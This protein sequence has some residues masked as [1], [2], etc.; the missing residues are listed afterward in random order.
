MK[1]LPGHYLSI[2]RNRGRETRYW[3]LRPTPT[4]LEITATDVARVLRKATERHMISDVPVGIYLSGGLDSTSLV[5]FASEFS[6]Q[7]I[8]TFS[9]GFGE[10]NDELTEARAV[11][12]HFRTVHHETVVDRG[13][14]AE[15][16]RLIWHMDSPKRNLYPYYLAQLAGKHVKV[17]LSGLGGD[18]LFAGYDFRYN[19]LEAAKPRTVGQK[20][21]AYLG[22]QARDLPPDQGKVYGDRIPPKSEHRAERFLKP[23]FNSRLPFMEQVLVADFNAKMIWDFLPVDD[24]T[25]MANSV[26]TRVPFLDDELVTLAFQ[27]PFPRK[28]KDGRGKL[29][30]REAVSDKLPPAVSAKRK[31]GFG[32]NPFNVYKRELRDY[33][34]RFLPNGR[35][36]KEGLIN[37]DWVS[38]TLK[39]SPDP[40]LI[41]Q[42]NKL[43]DCLALEIF[44]RVYFNEELVKNPT[45]DDL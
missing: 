19:A 26:E 35:S 23:Y 17:V 18:E 6:S 31:Q 39:T 1:I 45:W 42:Y 37:R 22:T 44:M 9:M 2:D 10:K 3:A 29:I 13:L 4:N 24:A 21:V 12:E 14:L 43:W 34:E 28:F 5:A 36:I 16:P 15:F 7:P 30:L 40:V 41:P 27:V 8:E 20:T 11:A 25:S 32:P 38:R 33:S